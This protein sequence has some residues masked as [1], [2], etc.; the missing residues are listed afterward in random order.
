[1]ETKHK[2]HYNEDGWVCQRYPQDLPIEDEERYIEV[3]EEEFIK[4]L[5]TNTHF[6]WRIVDGELV[7]E[8][9]Q[10]IP[11]GEIKERL[12]EERKE[13]LDAFDKWEKAVLRGRE[14]DDPQIMEWMQALLNLEEEAF[15]TIPDRI[16]YYLPKQP[17]EDGGFFNE[18][19]KE[20]EDDGEHQDSPKQEQTPPADDTEE[21]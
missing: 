3:G 12:R 2:I 5:S 7:N 10:E 16:A 6:A 18:E 19:E 14:E 11:E 4:S 9:Y 13:L 17:P 15:L 20:N 1:M 21:L 8:Q